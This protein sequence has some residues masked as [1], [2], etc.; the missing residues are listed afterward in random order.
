MLVM[1]KI[2]C[3]TLVLG[4]MPE[5]TTYQQLV[6]IFGEPNA[7]LDGYK[8]DAEWSGE[9]EGLPFTIYNYKT[10][11]AYLRDKGKSVEEITGED[12]HIGGQQEEVVKKII[13]L[14]Q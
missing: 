9:I 13:A 8:T 10:G 2:K 6:A 4:C 5:E 1:K 3:R 12:W 14:L 11:K 7:E